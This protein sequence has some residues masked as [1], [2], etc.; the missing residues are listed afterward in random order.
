M[1]KQLYIFFFFCSS[2]FAFD[3][4]Q[5]F[6][7][8]YTAALRGN[9]VAQFQTGVIYERGIGVEQNQTKAALWYE[10]SAEQGY[11]DA[12]YNLALMN[13]SGRGVDKNLDRA[14]M[15][16]TK[17][18]EQGDQD[19]RTL[20]SEIMGG[21]LDNDKRGG[22]DKPLYVN[23]VEEI[24]PVRLKIKEGGTVCTLAGECLAY[25][26]NT[27]ITSHTKRGSW[28][29]ISGIVTLKGW[30]AY[31]KEGWIREKDVDTQR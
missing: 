14:V 17:A 23:G 13:V 15:W 3:A 18:A 31:P 6:W 22:G 28:Y 11:L 25:K 16:L 26:E 19:A 1:K 27:V 4:S 12:Q 24:E 7:E 9:K 5:S 8:T 10:K 20:L 21:K 30:Q 2:L 29:K